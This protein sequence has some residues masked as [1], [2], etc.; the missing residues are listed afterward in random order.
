[1]QVIRHESAARLRVCHVVHSRLCLP[2]TCCRTASLLQQLQQRSLA[3][4]PRGEPQHTRSRKAMDLKSCQDFQL[5]DVPL[6]PLQ[7]LLGNPLYSSAKVSWCSSMFACAAL[8]HML[9][10]ATH[11]SWPS[12]CQTL[13]PSSYLAVVKLLMAH[14]L[15]Y[16]DHAWTMRQQLLQM[17]LVTPS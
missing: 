8:Q 10:V 6:I 2:A 14:T 5:Q 12:S 15:R 3:Q 16:N 4:H 1:M 13:A 11:H 7:V 9:P 17:M